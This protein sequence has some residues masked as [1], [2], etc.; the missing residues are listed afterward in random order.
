MSCV[1]LFAVKFKMITVTPT[2]SEISLYQAMLGE[3]ISN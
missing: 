3:G 2:S 1:F